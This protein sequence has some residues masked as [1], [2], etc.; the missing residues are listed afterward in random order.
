MSFL[1]CFAP[2]GL[3][4]GLASAATL[5]HN[6]WRFAP[7]A[8]GRIW[9]PRSRAP[10][11]RGF[12]TNARESTR[13][14]RNLHNKRRFATGFADGRGS[15]Q[16]RTGMAKRRGRAPALVTSPPDAPPRPESPPA[17][18]PARALRCRGCRGGAQ[19]RRMLDL[20]GAYQARPELVSGRGGAL[21]STA[22]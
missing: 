4:V 14:V 13:F 5:C 21:S 6:L 2:T 11:G 1:R 16:G 10:W 7:A 9:F 15:Q 22:R 12:G 20:E 18:R 19:H 8:S 17:V 3:A